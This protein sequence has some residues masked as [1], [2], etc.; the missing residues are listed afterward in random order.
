MRDTS[1]AISAFLATL[2]IAAMPAAADSTPAEHFAI[3]DLD[4]SGAL[5]PAEFRALID[6]AAAN[7]ASQARQIRDRGMYNRAFDRIDNDDNG[8][9]TI[10]ELPD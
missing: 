5:D 9:I 6:L 7:G 10:D 2:L 8:V 1:L 4:A 3:A